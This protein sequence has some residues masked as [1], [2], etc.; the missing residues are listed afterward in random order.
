[1]SILQNR[2]TQKIHAEYK[3]QN[4]NGA[5]MALNSTK[6]NTIIPQNNDYVTEGFIIRAI[7]RACAR[8]QGG[9]AEKLYFKSSFNIR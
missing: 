2:F 7:G 1:M 4:T 9:I 3:D 5:S 6:F 8:S